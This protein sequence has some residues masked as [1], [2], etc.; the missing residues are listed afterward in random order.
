[1]Y[2]TLEVGNSNISICGFSAEKH[3]HAYLFSSRLTTPK[4]TTTDQLALNIES[5][6]RKHAIQKKDIEKAIFSSVVPSLN[7][8]ITKLMNVYFNVNITQANH[9]HFK[10]IEI[11][12][13][14]I[15]SLGIDR[16]LCMK[17]IKTTFAKPS[18]IIDFGTAI[19]VNVLE[20]KDKFVGGLIMPGMIIALDALVQNT[21]QLPK[22]ELQYPT[23][24]LGNSTVEG[25]QN[26]IYYLFTKGIEYT[27]DD[28]VQSLF[29]AKG[30]EK[31][32]IIA[33]GGLAPY[34]TQDF[35]NPIKVI[36]DLS[37]LG[38]KIILDEQG[39]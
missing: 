26:G 1:M 6:L 34:I 23:K 13:G 2:L 21:S 32:L 19:T 11:S 20:K 25:M 35:K 36:P 10:D 8:N 38:L 4:L 17:A 30:L 33:T 27:I 18:I 29:T 16:L 5:I 24:I 22:I 28:L 3:T 12:Y 31:P 15:E 14:Q 7:H 9:S 39:L 37:S